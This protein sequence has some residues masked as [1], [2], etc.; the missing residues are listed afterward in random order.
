MQL[1][2]STF[3]EIASKRPEFT[4]I[5]DPEWNIAAGILHVRGDYMVARHIIIAGSLLMM[6]YAPAPERDYGLGV[7]RYEGDLSTVTDVI[8]AAPTATADTVAVL[9]RDSI[10][11]AKPRACVAASERMVEYEYEELGWAILAF[12]ADSSWAKVSVTALGTAEPAAWVHSRAGVSATQLWRTVL[13]Q[14]PLFFIKQSDIA[15]FRAP[16]GVTRVNRALTKSRNDTTRFDYIMNPIETRGPWMRV[17]VASPST[18]CEPPAPG[19]RTDTLWIRYLNAEQR[20][21]VFY[22]PRGC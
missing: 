10:C 16:D 4:S 9:A 8:R 20:P 19:A 3:K 12:S 2:P 21:A 6:A 5:D 11:F 13:P 15:F 17:E 14:K 22:Y 1:M 7:V 18:M